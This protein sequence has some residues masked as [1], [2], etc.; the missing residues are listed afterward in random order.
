MRSLAP[1]AV[2]CDVADLDGY[3][4]L[5]GPAEGFVFD[6]AD[7]GVGLSARLFAELDA[8]LPKA[9]QRLSECR[10]NDGCPACVMIG[11]CLQENE[12]VSKAGSLG[13]L[14]AGGFAVPG[15]NDG[16]PPDHELVGKAVWHGTHGVGIV[17]MVRQAAKHREVTV[18]FQSG[19]RSFAAGVAKLEFLDA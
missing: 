18:L 8:V 5:E 17:T 19:E 16:W 1:A 2:L 15:P 7:G 6:K 13:V 4:D 10:C 3:T 9:A 12:A 14:R 11:R